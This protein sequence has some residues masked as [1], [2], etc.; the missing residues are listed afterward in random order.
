MSKAFTFFKNKAGIQKNFTLKQ[1]RKTFLTKM[2]A[3]TGLVRSAGYPKNA[4]VIEK[5]YLK[6]IIISKK[7]QEMGFKYFDKRFLKC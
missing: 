3:K 1:I 5:N 6:N 4:S 2:E 7:I